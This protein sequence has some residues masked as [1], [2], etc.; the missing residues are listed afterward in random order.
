MQVTLNDGEQLTAQTI[1]RLRYAV[2]RARQTPDEKIGPQ[3]NDLTDLEGAAAELAFC[4][5]VNSWPELS[6][7]PDKGYDTIVS[8]FRIDVKSTT[9]E[10]GRLLVR[11][12]KRSGP[13]DWFVLVTGSFPGPY[14]IRGFAHRDDVFTPQYLSDL[15]YGPTYAVPQDHLVSFDDWTA[16]AV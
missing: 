7:T 2:S 10:G 13:A 11:P 6:I 9:V 1:A 15:G 8:G 3:S 14:T 5:A 12:E 4:K 16:Q